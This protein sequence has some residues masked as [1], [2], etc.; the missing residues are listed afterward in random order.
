[1]RGDLPEVM[2]ICGQASLQC[3][4][5]IVLSMATAVPE[6]VAN[7]F[8]SICIWRRSWEKNWTANKQNRTHNILAESTTQSS[9][10]HS[11]RSVGINSS[12]IIFIT[13]IHS[14]LSGVTLG[15]MFHVWCG[16]VCVWVCVW[17][18][19]CFYVYRFYAWNKLLLCYAM[20]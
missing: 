2:Q 17:V 5:I 7:A 18:C 1:M 8:L 11:A 12:F 4:T 10:H 19:V 13:V 6:F 14:W 16:F 15:F 3:P 9:P 20:L